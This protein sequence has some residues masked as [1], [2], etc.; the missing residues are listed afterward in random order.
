MLA[1]ARSCTQ[2]G[3]QTRR[4]LLVGPQLSCHRAARLV[5]RVVS[6]PQQVAADTGLQKEVLEEVLNNNKVH[7]DGIMMQGGSC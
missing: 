5:S 3:L 4:C 2:S 6:S 1:D 7:V